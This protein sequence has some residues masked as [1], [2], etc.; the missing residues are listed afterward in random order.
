MKKK[1]EKPIPYVKISEPT[2]QIKKDIYELYKVLFKN[3]MTFNIKDKIL[4]AIFRGEHGWRVVGI[5]KESVKLFKKY[6]YKN[7]NG[8]VTK[9]LQRDHFFKS[10]HEVHKE[11][12][13]GELLPYDQWWS[14]FW[15]NDRTVIVTKY[16]HYN[17]KPSESDIFPIDW[18]LGL[19]RTAKTAGFAFTQMREGRFL[20]ENF[21]SLV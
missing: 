7:P 4:T 8:I 21:D 15:D 17:K 3:S 16:E 1:V 18:E 14:T 12:L 2:E 20:R 11:M 13:K 5:S 9:E 10:R 6:D 19:F